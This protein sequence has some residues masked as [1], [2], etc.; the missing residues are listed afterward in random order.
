MNPNLRKIVDLL[1]VDET[2]VSYKTHSLFHELTGPKSSTQYLKGIFPWHPYLVLILILSELLIGVIIILW[3]TITFIKDDLVYSPQMAVNAQNC[4]TIKQSAHREYSLYLFNT[5]DLWADTGIEISK[6]DR[7]RMSFSGAFHSSVG[8]LVAE[9]SNNLSTPTV[10][11]IGSRSNQAMQTDKR[12]YCIDS[13]SDIGTILYRIEPPYPQSETKG[14]IEKTI[15]AEENKK[16]NG[17]NY[18]YSKAKDVGTLQ[19]TVNDI[20]FEGLENLRAYETDFPERFTTDSV[21]YFPD[22]FKTINNTFNNIYE[23]DT[24]LFHDRYHRMLYDDNLGQILL[25]AEIEHPVGFFN[26]QRAFRHL[27]DKI[28]EYQYYYSQSL[29]VF[30]CSSFYFVFFFLTH[31]LLIFTFWFVFF[32]IIIYLFYLVWRQFTKIPLRIGNYLRHKLL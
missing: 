8:H 10:K 22:F 2:K 11:W 6:N 13:N 7:F 1:S 3:G 18:S 23:K 14:K 29:M 15:R 30:I 5:S 20:Y 16:K 19:L 25:C 12:K 27:E 32:A 9:A 21:G 28:K 26:P 24:S 4:L 31:L 17:R